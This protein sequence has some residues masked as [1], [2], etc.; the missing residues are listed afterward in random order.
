MVDCWVIHH[1]QL[2]FHGAGGRGRRPWPCQC[3][4]LSVTAAD[5][6]YAA[7]ETM[8]GGAQDDYLICKKIAMVDCWVIHPPPLDFRGAGGRG[9]CPWPCQCVPLSGTAAEGL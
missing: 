8:A 3:A 7:V 2:D 1:P 5:G 4:P 6:P 9:R